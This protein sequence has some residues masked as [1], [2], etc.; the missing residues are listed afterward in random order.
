M[1]SGLEASAM[2]ATIPPADS[3]A[4][5]DL[6]DVD[7]HSVDRGATSVDVL[8]NKRDRFVLRGGCIPGHVAEK[9]QAKRQHR[10]F[11]EATILTSSRLGTGL[12]YISANFT[13]V[14]DHDL[15]T[16]TSR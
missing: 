8:F 14:R 15:K 13:T 16:P 12:G 6:K 5:D 2:K 3:V 4:E 1:V 10:T 11:F 9:G 7:G